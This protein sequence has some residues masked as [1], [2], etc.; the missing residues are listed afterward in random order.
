MLACVLD[1]V[2]TLEFT[3]PTGFKPRELLEIEQRQLEPGDVLPVDPGRIDAACLAA[4]PGQPQHERLRPASVNPVGIAADIE[5]LHQDGFFGLGKQPRFGTHGFSRDAGFS[6]GRLR[7]ELGG[8][9][10]D[11]LKHGRDLDAF[12]GE[13]AFQGRVRTIERDGLLLRAHGSFQRDGGV[14]LQIPV[15][16]DLV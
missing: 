1:H 14:R 2:A 6:G 8:F 10:L 9:R 16:E 12:D 11:L 13:S 4:V 5:P 3:Q 15:V 7:G